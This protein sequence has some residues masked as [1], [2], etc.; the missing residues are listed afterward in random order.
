MFAFHSV[1]GGEFAC[2][3]PQ[4]L[5][6]RLRQTTP[7]SSLFGAPECAIRQFGRARHFD[8][9][10][11]FRFVRASNLDTL[12]KNEALDVGFDLLAIS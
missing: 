11:Y 3:D 12:L 4:T 5:K 10:L 1:S 2:T 8:N 7:V 9:L 6:T